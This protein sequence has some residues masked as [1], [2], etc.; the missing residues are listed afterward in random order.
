MVGVEGGG[1]AGG[2]A[3]G[4][5]VSTISTDLWSTGSQYLAETAG[6]VGWHCAVLCCAVWVGPWLLGYRPTAPSTPC[7]EPTRH[8]QL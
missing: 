3:G 2:I 8:K 4:W 6:W 1:G 5:C 7:K